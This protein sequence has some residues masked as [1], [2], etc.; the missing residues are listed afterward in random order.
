[1][2]HQKTTV[3]DHEKSAVRNIVAIDR[4]LLFGPWLICFLIIALVGNLLLKERRDTLSSHEQSATNLRVTISSDITS[5]LNV[6]EVLLKDVIDDLTFG[7]KMPG[8]AHHQLLERASSYLPSATYLRV[9]DTTGHIVDDVGENVPADMSFADRDYFL[10]PKNDPNVGTYI[11]APYAS[12]LHGGVPTFALSRRISNPDGSFAG[13]AMIAIT[14]ANFEKL[15]T[16]LRLGKDSVIAVVKTDGRVLVRQPS[17]PDLEIVGLDLSSSPNFKRL[18]AM[19]TGTFTAKARLDGVRRAYFF[20]PVGKRP[21]IVSVGIAVDEIYDN[22]RTRAIVIAVILTLICVAL[23]ALSLALRHELRRRAIAEAHLAA[24]ATTDALTGLANRRRFDEV[25]AREWRRTRRTGSSLALL[26]IDA[27]HFKHLNDTYGHGQGDTVLRALGGLIASCTRRAGDCSARYGG[28]EFAVVLPDATLEEAMTTAEKI[29]A[30]MEDRYG[31]KAAAG[32]APGTTVSIGVAFATAKADGE[33][34]QLIEAA[35][36]ALYEAK[37][38][39][40]NRV[41]TTVEI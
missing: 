27:D 5:F 9:L 8:R 2:A 12:R 16:E 28:E 31:D 29:R 17:E 25:V 37:N 32:R 35:D 6:A 13:I 33:V 4:A 41:V 3:D 34:A 30:G 20:G 23:I 14:L 19:G 36:Q 10:V 40:R 22:W 15:F 24:L 38:T 21:L 7:A 11:S 1:M 18:L 26:M 39:G